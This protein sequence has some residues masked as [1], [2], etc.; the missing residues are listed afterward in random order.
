M[1]LCALRQKANFDHRQ[2]HTHGKLYILRNTAVFPRFTPRLLLPGPIGIARPS[3]FYRDYSLNLRFYLRDACDLST[4]PL[5]APP[6]G[7]DESLAH[8]HLPLLLD[9]ILL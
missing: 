4:L 2:E 9:L 1:F 7:L 6:C 3:R 8:W 5:A